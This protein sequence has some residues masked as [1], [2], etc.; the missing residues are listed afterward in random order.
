V[1]L[2]S[3]SFVQRAFHMAL[4][5]FP[6]LLRVEITH[7]LGY[8]FLLYGL[9]TSGGVFEETP[10]ETQIAS[11][12]FVPANAVLFVERSLDQQQCVA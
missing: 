12:S 11:K 7:A 1:L 10:R 6:T 2:G 5:K 3:W 4:L 9:G 8:G